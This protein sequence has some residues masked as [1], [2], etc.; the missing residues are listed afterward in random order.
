MPQT[1]LSREDALSIFTALDDLDMQEPCTVSLNAS[2]QGY[3][4]RVN[5]EGLDE[6]ALTEIRE[7]IEE[8]APYAA[9]QTVVKG[10][11]LTV[12]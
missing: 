5:I 12:L 10:S 8:A 11:Y 4:V 7:A 3:E 1:D 6:K 9:S 2:R